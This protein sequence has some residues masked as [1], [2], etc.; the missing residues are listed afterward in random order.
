MRLLS[1]IAAA[2][3][4]SSALALVAGCAGEARGRDANAPVS[5][6]AS[7]I[8]VATVAPPPPCKKIGSAEGVGRDLDE[9]VADTQ[10]ADAGREEAVKLGGDT[11]V[12]TESSAEPEAGSG[13]TA[14]KVRKKVDVYI[15]GK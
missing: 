4:V 5:S 15:C 13:G 7:K 1:R 10:A 14:M 2:S 11:M 9:K 12:V 8:N 6:E 3:I